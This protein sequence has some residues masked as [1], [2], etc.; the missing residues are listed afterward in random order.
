MFVLELWIIG[1]PNVLQEFRKCILNYQL[2]T[3]NLKKNSHFLCLKI[4][5]SLL[6]TITDLFNV[7]RLYEEAIRNIK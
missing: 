4:L 3:E 1:T 2:K 6:S 5:F 7:S